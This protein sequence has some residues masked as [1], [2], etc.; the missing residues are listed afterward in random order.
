MCVST[1]RRGKAQWE[2]AWSY[3]RGRTLELILVLSS[4]FTEQIG[5]SRGMRTRKSLS[6]LSRTMDKI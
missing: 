2:F 6:I 1:E 4:V 3:R 5:Q